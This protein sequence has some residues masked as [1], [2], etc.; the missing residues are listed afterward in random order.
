M[1]K[2]VFSWQ[3]FLL[4]PMLTAAFIFFKEMAGA[5]VGGYLISFAFVFSNIWVVSRFWSVQDGLFIKVYFFSIPLRLVL[6]VVAVIILLGVI[7]I[8]QI[9]F[10]V[11]FIISYLFN[12][13]SE[14]IFLLNIL[15]KRS[16]TH[17]V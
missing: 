15:Q 12:S 1:F 16:T 10:T 7:K 17:N 2:K 5:I 11:S 3:L 6:A 9:Y 14:L 13:V 4:I 8:D